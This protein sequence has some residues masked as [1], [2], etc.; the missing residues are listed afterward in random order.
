MIPL[1]DTKT[2]NFS[3]SSD[4]QK[5]AVDF[6]ALAKC[7]ATNCV[8]TGDYVNDDG[9]SS[10]LDYNRYTLS[11]TGTVAGDA[12]SLTIAMPMVA[13]TPHINQ[14]DYLGKFTLMDATTQKINKNYTVTPIFSD[15]RTIDPVTA[16]YDATTDRLTFQA[17]VDQKDTWWLTDITSLSFVP[18]A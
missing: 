6:L 3:T 8:A 4:L 15:G 16:T 11:Y 7:D 13:K 18:A 9:R 1:Q 14:N 10:T 5:E 2:L 12:L 17:P